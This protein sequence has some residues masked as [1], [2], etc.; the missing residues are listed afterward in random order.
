M[1]NTN[2]RSEN[3]VTMVALVT[4]IIIMVILLS[5]IS[6]SAKNGIEVKK[7]NDNKDKVFP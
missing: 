1:K 6:F 3:G 5:V 2:I 7:I 4:T